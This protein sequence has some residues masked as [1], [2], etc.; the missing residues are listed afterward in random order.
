MERNAL[1]AIALCFLILIT[2]QEVTR[3]LY[4]PPEEP[5]ATAPQATPQSPEVAPPAA[6][7]A[8]EAIAEAAPAAAPIEDRDIV[9]ENDLLRVVFSTAGGRLKNVKLKKFRQDVGPDSPPL[10]LVHEVP[11]ADRPLGLVLRRGG[12][13]VDDSTVLYQADRDSL[14]VSGTE[15][16]E[17]TL[18]GVLGGAQIVKRVRTTGDRYLLDI[19]VEVA[20]GDA[21]S[22]EQI[23]I[24][25]QDHIGHPARLGNTV[26]TT[27]VLA[28]QDSDLHRFGTQCWF[29]DRMRGQCHPLDDHA[30]TNLNEEG[31]RWAA[32]DGHYFLNAIVP[33][34]EQPD[35]TA[36]DLRYKSELAK[37]LV[38]WPKGALKA[39]FD[40]YLGPKKIDILESAPQSL[41]A[42]LDLGIFTFIALPLLHVLRLS[43]RL[44]GNYGVDIILLTVVI[45]ALFMPLTKKSMQSMR[46]MQKL[47]PQMAKIRERFKDKPDELNKE[48]IELYR[49]HKVNPLGGCLPMVLQIPVFIGLYQALLSAVELRHAPFFA[50]ITDLSA[51]DR[52]GSLH[53][54]F[55]DPP[56][57]P[58]LTLLMGVSMFIQQLMTPT[59]ADPAQ[60]RMML[61]MPVIFTFMFVSFPS[62]LA[63]YWLINNILTIAQQYTINRPEQVSAAGTRGAAA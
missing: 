61:I 24:A 29:L 28:I 59:G 51:P 60:Q 12:T 2:Y 50:W 23:G 39:N 4:P 55:I 6:P 9:V 11:A 36:L 57:V 34:T 62:G 41:R 13:D 52:L 14:S 25:W 16:G 45:K 27:S 37:L 21:P 49:R 63:L 20:P 33:K 58:V 40:L 32:F 10:E 47:Q 5:V 19:D 56:G 26:M 46:E 44:T 1:I 18:R 38:L 15:S 3:R 22:P 17:V 53:L 31:I 42:A 7:K 48:I 43:H 35:S 54:P 30:G 8:P